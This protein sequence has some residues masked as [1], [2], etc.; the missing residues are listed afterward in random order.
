MR[1]YLLSTKSQFQKIFFF[2]LIASVIFTSC[3][4]DDEI[5][6]N[7]N[8]FNANPGTIWNYKSNFDESTTWEFI[9]IKELEGLE[10]AEMAFTNIST[11]VGY[12]SQDGDRILLHSQFVPNL[13]LGPNNY[14]PSDG[15][16]DTLVHFSEPSIQ[17]VLNQPVGYTW[18]KKG[19]LWVRGNVLVET[20]VPMEVV[21]KEIIQTNAGTFACDVFKDIGGTFHYVSAE[22]I[23]KTQ[24]SS[25]VNGSTIEI[26]HEL[27][28]ITF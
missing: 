13:T 14:I 21:G 6:L 8:I 10:L 26:S 19:L 25:R 3:K 28:E 20:E 12:Y 22:G 24:A 9:Q 15:V 27:E 7:P 4:D 11:N 23:I 2:T 16:S 17:Y 18:I 5:K 1:N